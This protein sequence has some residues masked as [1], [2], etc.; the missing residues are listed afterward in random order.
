M[1]YKKIKKIEF[2]F[3]QK[4]VLRTQVDRER[5]RSKELE[6]RIEELEKRLKNI[7]T[8]FQH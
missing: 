4:K 1:I 3:F 5:Q 7:S 8:D 2:A 6:A